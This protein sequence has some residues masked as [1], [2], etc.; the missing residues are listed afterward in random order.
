[1]NRHARRSL[2]TRVRHALDALRGYEGASASGR[3]PW[4]QTNA[5]A[6]ERRA[7]RRAGPRSCALP[8]LSPTIRTSRDPIGLRHRYL[9]RRRAEPAARRSRRRRSLE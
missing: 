5:G 8:T 6:D 7:G 4:R 2:L 9:R 1:M 3:F